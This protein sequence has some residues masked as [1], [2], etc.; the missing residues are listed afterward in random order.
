MQEPRKGDVVIQN[1]I[2][3]FV[4]D[5]TA[6]DVIIN[7]VDGI[8]KLTRTSALAVLSTGQELLNKYVDRLSKGVRSL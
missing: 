1:D 3:G 7:A 2:I 8:K 5:I 6:A 4:V